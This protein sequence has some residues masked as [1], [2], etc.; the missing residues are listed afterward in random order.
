MPVVSAAKCGLD[1]VAEARL[2]LPVS[3]ARTKGAYQIRDHHVS[4]G[5][6]RPHQQG[7]TA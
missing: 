7:D 1:H 2:S 3:Q 5:F 6:L 4:I